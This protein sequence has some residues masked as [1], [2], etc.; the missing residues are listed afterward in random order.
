MNK[1]DTKATTARRVDE[2]LKRH[3]GWTSQLTTLRNILQATV[4][5]ETVKWGMPTYTLDGRGLHDRYRQ[6]RKPG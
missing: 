1:A 4:L 2:Y 6:A 5:E 3:P